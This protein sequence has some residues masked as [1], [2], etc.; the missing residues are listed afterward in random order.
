M[1]ARLARARGSGVLTT[2]VIVDLGRVGLVL[3]GDAGPDLGRADGQAN[4][5]L[6]DVSGPTRLCLEQV[7]L[8]Y[9]RGRLRYH[10]PEVPGVRG[11]AR[12]DP[13]TG[14]AVDSV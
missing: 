13:R 4:D 10:G 9:D 3:A 1:R 12:D 11:Q 6:L 2:Y 5:E 14:G 8:A 7:L